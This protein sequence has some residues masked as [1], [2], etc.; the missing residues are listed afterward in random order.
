MAGM[1][2]TLL[3]TRHGD[4]NDAGV[5]AFVRAALGLSAGICKQNEGP[6]EQLWRLC[7]V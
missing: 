4:E 7:E 5:A 6:M 2:A 3:G 1:I